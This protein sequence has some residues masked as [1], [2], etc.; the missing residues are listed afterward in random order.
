MR[1]PVS[2]SIGHCWRGLALVTVLLAGACGQPPP[3]AAAPATPGEARTFTGTWSFTGNRQLM[4]LGPGDQAAIFSVSGSLLLAG[5]ERP[6]LGFRAEII[7]FSDSQTGMVGRSVWI[8]Q[9]G[10]KAFSE[11]S[12]E[13]ALPGHSIKGRFIGG[14]GRYAGVTGEYS[15]TWQRLSESEDG[16]SGRVGDLAGWARL[17]APVAPAQ[18]GQ[19]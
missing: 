4:Q 12:G 19:Q 13:S 5:R 2:P 16:V 7:G 6:S 8:D 14:T 17:A 9:R 15:F 11:L 1:C 10:D 18:G 3:P